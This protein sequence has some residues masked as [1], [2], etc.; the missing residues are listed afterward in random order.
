[1]MGRLPDLTPLFYLAAFGMVCAVFV[2]TIGGIWIAYH[3]IM[4][5]AAYIG[6]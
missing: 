2:A 6:A 1:M 4:A 3:L 5:L